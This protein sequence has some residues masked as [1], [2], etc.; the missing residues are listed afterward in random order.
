MLDLIF[1]HCQIDSNLFGDVPSSF[2]GRSG[3]V[4]EVFCV[5]FT[6]SFHGT[7]TGKLACDADTCSLLNQMMSKEVAYTI[8]YPEFK[9]QNGQWVIRQTGIYHRFDNS[10]GKSLYLLFNP[11]PNST[12]HTNAIGFMASC[13][14]SST[15][16]SPVWLHQLV[17]STYLPTWRQYIA[18]QER[19]FLRIVRHPILK[20][21]N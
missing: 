21:S 11:T 10:T 8:R 1:S 20:I 15:Y 4:E 9:E 16:A 17:T 14:G 7:C 12:A 3:A 2:Y 5:P 18:A 13:A 6:L 19:D